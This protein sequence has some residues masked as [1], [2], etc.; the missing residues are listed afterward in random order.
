MSER[1]P[2]LRPTGQSGQRMIILDFTYLKSLKGILKNFEVFFNIGFLA[3]ILCQQPVDQYSVMHTG[4]ALPIIGMII[5]LTFYNC[6]ILKI[7]ETYHELPWHPIDFIISGL[8]A[9]SY[10]IVTII[11]LSLGI[12]KNPDTGKGYIVGFV[13]AILYTV[14]GIYVFKLWRTGDIPQGTD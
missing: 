1:E 14:D 8:M 11:V 3:S 4:I 13:N 6:Y 2:L 9:V 7:V 10:L 12:Q 5:L